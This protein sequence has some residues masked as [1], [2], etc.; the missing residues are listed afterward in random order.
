M[1]IT[2]NRTSGQG[3]EWKRRNEP[4]AQS[5]S[6]CGFHKKHNPD[7]RNTDIELYNVNPERTGGEAYTLP[8]ASLACLAAGRKERRSKKQVLPVWVRLLPQCQAEWPAHPG[9]SPPPANMKKSLNGSEFTNDILLSS[10]Q[11]AQ[12]ASA[13]MRQ[14]WTVTGRCHPKTTE[15]TLYS[16]EL[17][18]SPYLLNF[19]QP[20][21]T[22]DCQKAYWNVC[23]LG[24]LL[25]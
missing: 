15:H 20:R 3:S 21:Q 7:L 24:I 1:Q 14:L 11:R 4:R 16:G 17:G 19:P 10:R 13:L 12:E 18:D 25:Q 5:H 2:T 22:H 8:S 9:V 23:S 6:S